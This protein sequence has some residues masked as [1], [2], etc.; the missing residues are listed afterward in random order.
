MH[1]NL[2]R[3]LNWRTNSFKHQFK[4]WKISSIAFLTQIHEYYIEKHKK[5]RDLFKCCPLI[6]KIFCRETSITIKEKILRKKGNKAD[7]H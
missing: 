1:D 3:H 4:K 2:D 5:E 7:Q 6:N